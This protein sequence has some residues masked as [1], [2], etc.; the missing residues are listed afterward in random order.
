MF[1]HQVLVWSRNLLAFLN[2]IACQCP[3]TSIP[4][5]WALYGHGR[6]EVEALGNKEVA[7]EH[8]KEVVHGKAIVDASGVIAVDGNAHI[9]H[10]IHAITSRKGHGAWRCGECQCKSLLCLTWWWDTKDKRCDFQLCK[11]CD[12][13]LWNLKLWAHY[14]VAFVVVG[15]HEKVKATHLMGRK[16]HPE[17]LF[18][19]P[20]MRQFAWSMRQI[21]ESCDASIKLH[22]SATEVWQELNI[23]V[24]QVDV[25]RKLERSFCFHMASYGGWMFKGGS[26][27][28]YAFGAVP[29]FASGFTID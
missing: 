17:M 5:P 15:S 29:S 8:N 12:F 3:H 16:R 11:R 27:L 14:Y 10:T 4:Y 25:T 24:A 20:T 13:Q 19:S 7:E 22:D 21:S 26:Q 9:A 18:V 2:S 23:I 28:L 6:G 1:W